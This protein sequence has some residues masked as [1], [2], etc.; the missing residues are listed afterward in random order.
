MKLFEQR[1]LIRAVDSP[2]AHR[3]AQA[4]GCGL[5]VYKDDGHYRVA[6]RS[7]R[8]LKDADNNCGFIYRESGSVL[9]RHVFN[10]SC[11]ADIKWFLKKLNIPFPKKLESGWMA[12]SLESRK[13]KDSW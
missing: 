12:F 1:K 9:V 2:A 6:L 13:W 7:G 3:E 5:H 11:A 10:D 8:N 4:R